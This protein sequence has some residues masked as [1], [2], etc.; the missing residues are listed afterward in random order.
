MRDRSV[1]VC[2][3]LVEVSPD[4]QVGGSASRE[5]KSTSFHPSA[6]E[7]LLVWTIFSFL[8]PINKDRVRGGRD[9]YGPLQGIS[10]RKV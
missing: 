1:Q 9:W 3:R 7:N 4:L 8:Q 10:V 5:R 2:F 6:T